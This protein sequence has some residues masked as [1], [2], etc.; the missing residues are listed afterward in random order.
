MSTPV[1]K[2]NEIRRM[3]Y[4]LSE[5]AKYNGPQWKALQAAD[6]FL[7]ASGWAILNDK[8]SSAESFSHALSYIRS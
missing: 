5:T 8:E 6:W 2:I 4:D 3:I 7:S 1:E